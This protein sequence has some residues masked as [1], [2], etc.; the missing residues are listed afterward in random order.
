M[1]DLLVVM[2]ELSVKNC[3]QFW[4]RE[5]CSSNGTYFSD[6][7]LY[8][9]IRVLPAG[10]HFPGLRFLVK[11]GNVMESNKTDGFVDGKS[12]ICACGLDKG[13]LAHNLGSGG[14]PSLK[15]CIR[16]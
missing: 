9:C 8:I 14:A 6:T 11:L 5:V 13:R 10:D 7:L 15:V 3:I 1:T 4:S 2:A 12:R 16:V